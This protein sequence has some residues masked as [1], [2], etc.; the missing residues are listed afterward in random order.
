MPT[1]RINDPSTGKTIRLV[2][3]SPP[4]EQEL[5]EV[6][7]SVGQSAPE[8]SAMS[9][10]YQAPQRTGADPYASMFQAGSPQQLQTAVDDAGKIGE[11]KSVQGESGQY[12]TPYFQ[13]PGVMTAPP[14]A[15]TSEEEKKRTKEA[16]IQAAITT[17][18][19]AP[20]AAVGAM[21]GGAGVIPAAMAMGGAGFA[22]EVLGQTGEYLA[23]QRK[24]FSEGQL[25]KGGVVSAT[26]VLRPFQGT[27]GPVA[28]GLAQGS[29]QA[30]VNAATAAFGETLQKYIDQG[31][32]PTLEEIGKEIS[33]PAIFGFTTGGA[34]G[35]LARPAR[36]LTTEEQIAQ[37]GRQAGQ[38]LEET[39]GAGTAPLTATQ[40]TGRNVPG[41]FGPG[42]SGLAAQQALPERIR[43]QLGIPAQQER[44]TAQVAQQEV[45]GAEAASRQAL[46]GSA[47]GAGGQA[48][49][50]VEGVIGSIL[51]RS[52]RAAS[53][54]DA[55]N[56]SVGFIRGEDQ[57]LSG[58]VDDAYNTARTA[59]TTRLGGQAEVPITPGQNLR[60][61]I[62]DVL[63]TLAT[64]ERITV[65]PS[66]I[67]GGTPTTTVERIPSQ[68]FNEASSRARALRDVASSPQTFEQI[69]GLRQS[70]DGLIHYFDEFA[71]GVAQNQL[72]RLRS[73]LKQEELA[74]ARRL[75]IENEVVAAQGVAEN[76]FNL[77]QD[78]PI[79]R[80]ATIPA[81]DGGYQN[82]EQFFSDLASSPA[83]FESVRNLLTSTAQGRIQ[84]D[85]IR[86]GFVDSLRG[87]G[88]VD[89]GGVPTE[90]LSSFANNFREL[91]QGVRNIV[92]GN[93]ANANRLQSILNDAVRTQNVGMSIPVATGISP[94]ALTEITDNLGTIASPTLRNTV[95]NLA[96]QSRDR[97][98]EFFNTTTRRVQRNQLNPDTDPSQFVRYFVFRSENPQVVQN[99]LNQLNPATRDAV[100]ANAAIAVLNHVSETGPANVRRG[101]Q[102]LDDIV[103]D[104]NRMQIIRD[105]LEPNDFNMINDYMAWNRARN[106]T[107]QG[108]RLQPDQ[109]ANSVMRATRARWVVD[110]LVGSPTVQN[111]LSGAVRLPQTF[112]NLKPNLT[113]PQAE[114]LAKASNM[115]LLQ[116]NREWDNLSK[117]SEEA[118]NS[119]PE[120]KRG[121]FDDTLGVPP[122]PRF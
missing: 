75:G 98:E 67:I 73:A 112:S 104:P 117:K 94:Q 50:E 114:A 5:E 99:A 2:G 111:F 55:A 48:V 76:R 115:S 65:T 20:V 31:R 106:L 60:D 33:L 66:P 22:G 79:I 88:T 93:E 43:G 18:R 54:Q 34:T 26:P 82:T 45:L 87:A 90:S 103:Q 78:N 8:P 41:T 19:I 91:P 84:F 29:A 39:L 46:R 83:G 40:Q 122:R 120:D 62:D 32:L 1:Y 121:I 14:S 51:P 49:G 25:V 61:T 109:L 10:Q 9:A 57:R 92:A 30:G 3:D 89:I 70:V 118:R 37:Q 108:G 44:A 47:A 17:A 38:R 35:A 107:A 15:A 58:I 71:P 53:L 72:K 27:A 113:L 56:N 110:A 80:R 97:A 24:D 96:R 42:S 13:R 102:S 21:T 69:V 105:V 68:F 85:Q 6:F 63:G 100:R 86:R 7:K 116:F 64:E 77:L 59:R 52:P 101:I 119:L 4:T 11:Q 36:Q 12:V 74:S 95:A 23:G 16:A 81:R 28:A